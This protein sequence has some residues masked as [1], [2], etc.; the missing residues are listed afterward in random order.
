MKV[1][2]LSRSERNMVS[3]QELGTL[4]LRRTQLS[5]VKTY[6]GRPGE[7]CWYLLKSYNSENIEKRKGVGVL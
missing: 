1:S 2:G 4:L 5:E 7:G 6:L 3:N